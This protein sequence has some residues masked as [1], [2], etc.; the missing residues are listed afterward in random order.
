MMS[1]DTD[2]QWCPRLEIISDVLDE[3]LSV[4]AWA[5]DYRQCQDSG[6]FS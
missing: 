1:S 3:R 5:R 6:A 4:V 2:Y